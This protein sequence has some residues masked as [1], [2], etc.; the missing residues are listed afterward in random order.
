ML[1]G[2]AYKTGMV[3]VLH[4]RFNFLK[5]LLSSIVVRGFLHPGL[6]DI[7]VGATRWVAVGDSPNRSYAK[8][9]PASRI[10][11]DGTAAWRRGNAYSNVGYSYK[12]ATFTQRIA[13]KFTIFLE[14]NNPVERF[15]RGL[16][17][18]NIH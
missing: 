15:K 12:I 13:I 6:L 11:A 17:N 3:R 4:S 10:H 5:T 1:S 16:R 14:H 7:L 2:N 18:A 8:V 9:L